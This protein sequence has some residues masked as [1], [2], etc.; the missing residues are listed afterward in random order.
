MTA[1]VAASAPFEADYRIV[2]PDGE[3]RRLQARA[4]VALAPSDSVTV[5]GLRGIC[6]D[7]TELGTADEGGSQ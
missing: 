4:E 2:R 5:A 3:V 7:V 6:Q 1:A